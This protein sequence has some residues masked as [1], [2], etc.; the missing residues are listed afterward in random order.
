MKDGA[1]APMAAAAPPALATSGDADV[2]DNR[3]ED[4]FTQAGNLFRIMSP[5]QQQQLFGNIAG[6]LV[7]ATS[8][9]QERMLAQFEQ[10]DAAYAAG[11][12]A[13]LSRSS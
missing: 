12:R 5:D 6:A 9:V 4:N 11:V 13:A 3:E 1:P 8:S 7:H 2:F 10:A